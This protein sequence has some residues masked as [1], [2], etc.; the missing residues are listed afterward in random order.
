MVRKRY[1]TR[2][3]HVDTR[4]TASAPV[5]LVVIGGVSASPTSV[6]DA[7]GAPAPTVIGAGHV[8]HDD[9]AAGGS[10]GATCGAVAASDTVVTVVAATAIAV[11]AAMGVTGGAVYP[12]GAGNDGLGLHRGK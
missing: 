12:L 3:A 1:S 6:S 7:S 8:V 10:D 9:G 2:A 5:A 11:G 4:Q